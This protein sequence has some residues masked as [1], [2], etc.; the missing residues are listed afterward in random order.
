MRKNRIAVQKWGVKPLVELS[1]AVQLNLETDGS[2]FWLST[3]DNPEWKWESKN[4]H[5]L[6]EFKRDALKGILEGAEKYGFIQVPPIEWIDRDFIN[7][8]SRALEKSKRLS[9]ADMIFES[10]W[11]AGRFQKIE[12]KEI[13]SKLSK[14]LGQKISQDFVYKR[15]FY[16]G[17]YPYPFKSGPK[18]KV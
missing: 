13:A 3:P 4:A 2:G 14:T 10:E 16:R 1:R 5:T 11:I 9:D 12:A 18:T 15:Y 7:R 17:G 8:L 6:E